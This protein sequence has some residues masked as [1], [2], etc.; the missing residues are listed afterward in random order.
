MLKKM[1]INNFIFPQI[2][3]IDPQ[4]LSDPAIEKGK[5]NDLILAEADINQS[6]ENKNALLIVAIE[7]GRIDIVET[8]ITERVDIN[9]P[10]EHGETPLM[11]A[12]Y[13]KQPDIIKALI[14]TGIDIHP[15]FIDAI[16]EGDLD[17][18]NTLIAVKIDVNKPDEKGKL[19]ILLA[20]WSE[21]PD[22]V[23]ALIKA[24]AN[25]NE[26]EPNSR[27]YSPLL[28][29]IL[30][31]RLD[32]IEIL[33]EAGGDV[34]LH[35][36][37][38]FSPF[39]H[40][41]IIG[42]LK[43]IEF[44]IK[45]GANVDQPSKEGDYPIVSAIQNIRSDI[46]N[47]LVSAKAN[48]HRYNNTGYSLLHL[49]MR[50]KNWDIVKTLVGAGADV[51]RIDK[52]GYSPL[53]LA[54]ILENSDIF[55][56]LLEAK[57]DFSILHNGLPLIFHAI[58]YEN[59][60]IL[61]AL[62]SVD[63]DVNQIDETGKSPVWAAVY[64]KN[65]NILSILIESGASI[66]LIDKKGKS[67]LIFAKIL[68][69]KIMEDILIKAG[70]DNQYAND[71]LNTK[72][73]GHCW[74]IKG[75]CLLKHKN[76]SEQL[77]ELQGFS[78][79]YTI[80][81]ITSYI[82]NFLD[83]EFEAG[84][85]TEQTIS[86]IKDTFENTWLEKNI[87]TV[88]LEARIDQNKPTLFSFSS[89]DHNISII[90]AE[91][92]LIFC[93][94]GSGC[95]NVYTTEIYSATSKKLKDFMSVIIDY[96]GTNFLSDITLS[97]DNVENIYQKIIT[98][99][100][101]KLDDHFSR[102][103]QKVGNCTWASPKAAFLALLYIL[104]EN[105]KLDKEKSFIN[106]NR[107]YK[108]FTIKVR[109]EV[110]FDFIKTAQFASTSLPISLLKIIRKKLEKKTSEKYLR[111]LNIESDSKFEKILDESKILIRVLKRFTRRQ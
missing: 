79:L 58:L 63:A 43:I 2:E 105:N 53:Y 29:A 94:R 33:N 49:A 61:K 52:E 46:V 68:N 4:A 31:Q 3:I 87:E 57:A 81:K 97:S 71:Y 42:N 38:G 25:P 102:K 7:E 1:N 67:P 10:N 85:L 51:N 44:L 90:L 93:N 28:S 60:D 64:K 92:R 80:P 83:E 70:A 108:K 47:T 55:K 5:S 95:S 74:G 8:L 27:G 6:V 98:D 69:N 76:A 100:E 50:L 17:I 54:I 78:E 22:I 40:A 91:N 103:Y 109:I 34:N 24:G 23:E 104:D 99:P 9:K 65:L 66:D 48:I 72:F 106:A 84:V 35:D 111:K 20:I 19:P 107:I 36:L 77:I 96:S 62:I 13:E 37:T 16:K 75:T 18:V 26:P 39:F 12:I 56:I 110:L 21:R 86:T 14:G 82:S 41:V 32:I 15:L 45:V 73:L 89:E 88:E 30:V 59:S 11:V 101:F